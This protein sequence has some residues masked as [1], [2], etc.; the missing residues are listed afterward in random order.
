MLEGIDLKGVIDQ[1]GS[2][3]CAHFLGLLLA[4][5]LSVRSFP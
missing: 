1:E 3:E 2:V 4:Y 5:A